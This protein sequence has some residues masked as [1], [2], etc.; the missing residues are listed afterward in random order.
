MTGI[1]GIDNRTENWTTALAFAPLFKNNAIL[2]VQ[3]LGESASTDAVDAHLELFWR[4]VRDWLY[5]SSGG[6]SKAKLREELFETYCEKFERLRDDIIAFG[7]FNDLNRINYSTAKFARKKLVSNLAG[8]EI[9]IVVETPTRLYIGE[10]KLESGFGAHGSIVLVHQLVR[11]YVAAYT[12]KTIVCKDK[13]LVPFVVAENASLLSQQVQF[14]LSQGWMR[15][16]H[17]LTWDNIREIA[18]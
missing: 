13:E 15:E 5:Q 14:M 10:A 3:A 17:L 11:Q 18:R 4:G 7:G 8:T 6:D 1:L 16:E 9:D 2:L 12:L